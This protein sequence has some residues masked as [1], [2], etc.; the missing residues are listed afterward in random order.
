MRITQ[1]ANPENPFTVQVSHTEIPTELRGFALSE[2]NCSLYITGGFG[3]G[4]AETEEASE[5]DLE[6]QD[7][8]RALPEMNEARASHSSSTFFSYLVV[9]CGFS[10]TRGPLSSI[11]MLDLQ[12]IENAR[13]QAV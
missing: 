1:Y 13:G 11:E 10:F 5:F 12:A 2:W 4:N 9:M 3:P 8:L 6:K 7:G